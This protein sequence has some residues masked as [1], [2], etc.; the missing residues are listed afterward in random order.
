MH[1][2]ISTCLYVPRIIRS[3]YSYS[4]YYYNYYESA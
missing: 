3:K 2:H 1:L 4:Y